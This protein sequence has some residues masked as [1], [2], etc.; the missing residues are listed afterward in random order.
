MTE[1]L[2]KDSSKECIAITKIGRLQRWALSFLGASTAVVVPTLK[3]SVITHV[4]DAYG[5]P[6]FE[7]AIGALVFA[8]L[9]WIIGMILGA[10]KEKTSKWDYILTSLGVPA[11]IL[12]A[13]AG[14]G[15]VP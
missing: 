6:K 4:V 2:N 14:G 13:L 1:C 8:A 9:I 11:L 10:H 15:F 3:A 5:T 7:S 12:G